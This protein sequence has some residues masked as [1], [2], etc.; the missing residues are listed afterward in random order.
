MALYARIEDG[1]VIELLETD[2]D[3][4]TM[5]PPIYTWVNVDNVEGIQQNWWA[6]DNGAGWE[7]SEPGVTEA[8]L[9]AMAS[10]ARYQRDNL[11]KSV[12]DAGILMAQRELRKT[13]N[14][15]EQIDY[16]NGKIAE[17]DAYAV[18]LTA[19]PDQSG[20]PQTIEWPV[21]PTV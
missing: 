13:D 7:F 3:I 6:A 11:L 9:E 4:S 17:L 12:C 21:A 14:T 8:E 18:E 5:F 15:Q 10:R 2:G 1:I 20:F 19:V 16:I